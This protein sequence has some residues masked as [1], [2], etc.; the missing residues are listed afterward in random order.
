MADIIRLLK[1][2]L[3]DWYIIID[4]VNECEASE[5]FLKCLAGSESTHRPRIMLFGRQ[6]A[7]ILHRNALEATTITVTP[8]LVNLDLH[9]FFMRHLEDR[10]FSDLLDRGTNLDELVSSLLIGANGA[11]QWAQLMAT[12]LKSEVLPVSDR[13]EAIRR[14]RSAESLEDMYARTLTVIARRPSVEQLSARRM[15]MWI[16]FGKGVARLDQF[17]D[18][19]QM[20]ICTIGPGLTNEEKGF[21]LS[22]STNFERS[23]SR[24]CGG[25]VEVRWSEELRTGV[26]RF[27][28]GTAHKFFPRKCA[29]AGREA[30]LAT[31]GIE[32]LHPPAFEAESEMLMLCFH[33]CQVQRQARTAF[34]AAS[35]TAAE[36]PR[37]F[38]RYATVS[39]VE[40]LIQPPDDAEKTVEAV[41][42]M[43]RGFLDDRAGMLAWVEAIYT[44]RAEFKTITDRL[45]RWASDVSASYSGSLVEKANEVTKLVYALV[46]DLAELDK[47][48][49]YKLLRNPTLLRKDITAF[50]HSL[51]FPQPEPQ[52]PATATV[53]HP[54]P[55][56]APEGL[57]SLSSAPLCQISHE[58]DGG[59]R[60]A[61]LKIW[62]S[63]AFANGS[64]GGSSPAA[65]TSNE[66][67]QAGL[68]SIKYGFGEKD[69]GTLFSKKNGIS[70]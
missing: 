67:Y 9:R 61:T 60:S 55:M 23:I 54:V 64:Q 58:K 28:N 13:V 31:G 52:P 2:L 3:S 11:F 26:C 27:V 56:P 15:F 29:D 47:A 53:S 68:L 50:S 45:R 30:K 36:N 22:L 14:L 6:N 10:L 19:L 69:M 70:H 63:V 48:W 18:L 37:P 7:N 40:H 5:A 21:H 20:L 1:P 24:A 25:L 16:V 49:R 65:G 8:A 44:H 57:S 66:T 34:G 42:N 62:P 43:L 12:Y 38:L 4:A 46:G 51:F 39:W 41:L 59:G 35:R 17:E 32:Y 33:Y